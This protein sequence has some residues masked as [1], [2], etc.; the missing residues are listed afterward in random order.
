ML[1]IKNIWLILFI[2]WGLPLGYYRSKFRK[3]VYQ[4]DSW[5]N[6]Q[7][8][9]LKELKG[10]FWKWLFDNMKCKKFRNIYRLALADGKRGKINYWC[11]KY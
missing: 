8:G 5:E 10:H 2:V 11:L 3:M 6:Y 7:T 9:F 1:L 4:T